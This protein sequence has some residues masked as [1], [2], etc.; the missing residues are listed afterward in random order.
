[1]IQA[2]FADQ[3]N[4]NKHSNMRSSKSLRLLTNI[5][6]IAISIFLL[7]LIPTSKNLNLHEQ[8]SSPSSYQATLSGY[9]VILES[10]NNPSAFPS[11]YENDLKQVAINALNLSSESKVYY[12]QHQK[13]SQ[14]SKQLED[15]I[16]KKFPELIAHK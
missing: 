16:G 1:M 9:L 3:Y 11:F 6:F 13:L 15:E 12:P 4:T 14:L 2:D 8:I 7:F 10:H 5:V